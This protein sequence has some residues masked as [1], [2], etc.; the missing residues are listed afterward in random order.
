MKFSLI[1]L[2]NNR[3]VE[4]RTIVRHEP[5]VRLNKLYV[6]SSFKGTA[7]SALFSPSRRTHG[8]LTHLRKP[9]AF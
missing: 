5:G 4:E 3:G 8:A 2:K 9:R 1:V 7:T 6:L